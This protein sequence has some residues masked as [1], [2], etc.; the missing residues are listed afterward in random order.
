MKKQAVILTVFAVFLISG[1][2]N[3]SFTDAEN[4][5][6]DYPENSSPFGIAFGVQQ[7][8]AF[9]FSGAQL[10]QKIIP[11]TGALLINTSIKYILAIMLM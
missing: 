1:C 4:T 11:M 6:A 3:Q 7:I 2:V 10:N 5:L 9:M 8:L